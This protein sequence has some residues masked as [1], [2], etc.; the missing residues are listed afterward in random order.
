[1]SE[2]AKRIYVYPEFTH[3]VT[4]Q[5]KTDVAYVRADLVDELIKAVEK[6]LRISD[7]NHDAWYAA[8]AALAALK[9]E[10]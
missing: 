9:E 5:H 2:P 7:R 4:E 8:R 3:T 10:R 6:V 1:M